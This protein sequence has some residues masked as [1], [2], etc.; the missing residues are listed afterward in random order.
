MKILSFII[1][2]LTQA[3]GSFIVETETVDPMGFSTRPLKL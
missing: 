3:Q 1:M 2:P